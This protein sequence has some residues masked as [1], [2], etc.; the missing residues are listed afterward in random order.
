MKNDEKKLNVELTEDEMQNV[1]GGTT[2][3]LGCSPLGNSPLGSTL[4]G[5]T[6]L[7]NSVDSSVGLINNSIGTNVPKTGSKSGLTTGGD[8]DDD[9]STK[10][11]GLNG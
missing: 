6:P 8:M 4:L 5:N 3:P 7:G 2:I 11:G 9:N 10:W 1:A